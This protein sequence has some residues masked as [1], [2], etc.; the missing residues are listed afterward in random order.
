M[1]SL[2]ARFSAV[3]LLLSLAASPGWAQSNAGTARASAGAGMSQEVFPGDRYGDYPAE[4]VDHKQPQALLV[5][6]SAI[7]GAGAGTASAFS[8]ASFVAAAGGVH[9]SAVASGSA[10]GTPGWGAG[11]GSAAYADAATGDSFRI[12]APAYALGALFTVNASLSLSG[13]AGAAASLANGSG[14]YDAL[15]SWQA[16]VTVSNPSM[17]Y[18]VAQYSSGACWSSQRV[19]DN[20]DGAGFSNLALQFT[21]ANGQDTSLSISGSAR[22]YI[23]FG[24]SGDASV[25]G[26]AFAD[27]GNTIAWG[28]ISSLLDTDGQNIGDYAAASDGSGFDYREAFVSSVPEPASWMLLIAGLFLLPLRRS[29]KPH[30]RP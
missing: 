29:S 15:S 2:P 8:S 26:N 28:G 11:G 10:S 13:S 24:A 27:L 4:V 19:P 20:C 17:L 3:A 12:F 21:V 1:H 30:G 23:N 7:N 22:A 6:G 18:A 25:S 16:R 14:S 9:V 5:N